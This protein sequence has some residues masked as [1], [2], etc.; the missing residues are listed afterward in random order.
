[1]VRSLIILLAV[2][3]GEFLPRFDLIMGLVGGALSSPLIFFLPPL[4]YSRYR[5]LQAASHPAPQTNH[6]IQLENSKSGSSMDSEDG[7]SKAT[8]IEEI[9]TSPSRD[10]MTIFENIVG[11]LNVRSDYVEFRGAGRLGPMNFVENVVMGVIISIGL[12]ATATA[13][14]VNVR[15]AIRY[16]E[17]STPACI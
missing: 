7:E 9:L 5:N 13:T 2:L 8:S 16:A 6:P 3:V 4:L 10:S 15:N 11:T 12:I 1:M 14:F 17:Y